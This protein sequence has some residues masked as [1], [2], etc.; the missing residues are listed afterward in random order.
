V[1]W[2]AKLPPELGT[3]KENEQPT[4]FIIILRKEPF[5][6]FAD[7]DAGIAA[8]KI[9]MTAWEHGFGS[10]ILGSIHVK[11]IQ[12]VLDLPEDVKPR[13]AIALGKPAH[14]STIVDVPDSGDLSYYL[15]EK[16]DYYVPKRSFDSIVK[17]Y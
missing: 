14:K 16:R 12:Q 9:C 5:N 10:C 11:R 1:K 13:I 4:A 8:D 3:P 6:A 15:D 17:I 7:I 2:A